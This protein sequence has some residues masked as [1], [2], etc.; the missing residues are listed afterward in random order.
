MEEIPTNQKSTSILDMYY[1]ERIDSFVDLKTYLSEV[2]AH[3]IKKMIERNSGNIS[4]AA[5]QLGLHRSIL[6]RKLNGYEK[7]K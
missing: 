3:C 2:E 7:R 1:E 6:Y 4:K 5:S